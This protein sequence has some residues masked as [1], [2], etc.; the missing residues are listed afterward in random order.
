MGHGESEAAPASSI[1]D[2]KRGGERLRVEGYGPEGLDVRGRQQVGIDVVGHG[3]R[4]GVL[5]TDRTP[6]PQAQAV[7]AL[8]SPV[9]LSLI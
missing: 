9:T 7:K 2:T 6:K 8:Y 4:D 1:L 3:G 5:F